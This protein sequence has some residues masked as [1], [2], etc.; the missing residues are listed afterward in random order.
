MVLLL[1]TSTMDPWSQADE[2][3]QKTAGK[4]VQVLVHETI[5]TTMIS[6]AENKRRETLYRHAS[7]L[8]FRPSLHDGYK[9]NMR[10]RWWQPLGRRL[11][12]RDR[13]L[14]RRGLETEEHQFDWIHPIRNM[15]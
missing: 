6:V 3:G 4:P 7:G 8:A 11:D 1:E 10:L 2:T 12:A 5:R 15:E 14:R 9:G 13:T